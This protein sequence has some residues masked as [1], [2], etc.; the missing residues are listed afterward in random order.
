MY[1]PAPWRLTGQGWLSVFRVRSA[2]SRPD[3]T[4]AVGFVDYEPGGQL[5]YSELLVARRLS[6]TRNA[7]EVTDIWVDSV[8]SCEGGRALWAIPKELCDFTRESTRT[9]PLSRAEWSASVSGRP[10]AEAYFTDVS[11]LAPRMPF[12]G[13]TR[14]PAVDGGPPRSGSFKGTAKALP[15]RGRWDFAPDSPLAWLRHQRQLASLRIAD[16]RMLFN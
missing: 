14:Q 16:F 6:G 11:R 4:Y 2:D 8:E 7:V 1:P 5:S 9:G 15:C 3:G 13:R 10:I 12:S